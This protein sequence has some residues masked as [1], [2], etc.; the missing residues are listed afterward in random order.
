MISKQQSESNTSQPKY[1]PQNFIAAHRAFGALTSEK[2]KMKNYCFKFE[3]SILSTKTNF[4]YWKKKKEGRK[5]NIEKWKPTTFQFCFILFC[6]CLFFK[7]DDLCSSTF[8]DL[9]NKKLKQ[10][11]LHL[12]LFWNFIFYWCTTNRKKDIVLFVCL[13]ANKWIWQCKTL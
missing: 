4:I 11:V 8:G 12:F 9:P 5:L 6:S 7:S 2:M 1:R 10:F 3:I 13:R